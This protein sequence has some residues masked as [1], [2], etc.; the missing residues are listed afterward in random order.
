MIC[1]INYNLIK[2]LIK[3][4]ILFKIIYSSLENQVLRIK[5]LVVS[6]NI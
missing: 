3:Q 5:H 6:T 4:I 1:K 2:L